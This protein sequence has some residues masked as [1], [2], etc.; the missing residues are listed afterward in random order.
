M[1]RST[2]FARLIAAVM[3]RQLFSSLIF[4][5]S[6]IDPATSAGVAVALFAANAVAVYVRARRAGLVDPAQLLRD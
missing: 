1:E 4:A 5:I 6:P 3:P 2:G